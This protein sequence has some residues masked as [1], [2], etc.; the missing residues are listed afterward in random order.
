MR[1]VRQRLCTENIA[2]IALTRLVR[3]MGDG[4]SAGWEWRAVVRR[5]GRGGRFG[6][7]WCYNEVRSPETKLA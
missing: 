7:F 6:E 1:L 2:G 5:G 4:M 3:W